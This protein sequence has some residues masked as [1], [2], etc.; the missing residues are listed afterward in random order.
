MRLSWPALGGS[1]ALVTAALAACDAGAAVPRSPQRVA[2]AAGALREALALTGIDEVHALGFT[3]AGITVAVL[4]SGADGSHPDLA[5]RVAGEACFCGYLNCCPDGSTE[6]IGAGSARDGHG[7]GT[8]VAAEIASQGAIGASGGAPDANLLAIKVLRDENLAL[9]SP[10]DL[11]A[12]LDWIAAAHPEVDVVNMSLG[13]DA[14][15]ADDCDVVY[16][17][18]ADAVAALRATGTLVVAASGNDGSST[19]MRAPACIGGALSVGAVWDADVGAQAQYC[20]EPATA[21]DR[22]ACYTNTSATTDLLAPGGVIEASWVDGGTRAQTG[23][24]HAAPLVSACI[25]A[26]KQAAPDASAD[27]IELALEQSGTPLLDARNGRTYPRLDCAAALRVLRP[28]LVPVAED[29]GHDDDAGE[30][31]GTTPDAGGP[32]RDAGEPRD[33]GDAVDGA[34]PPVRDASATD[35]AAA[36]SA[37]PDAATETDA[38]TGDAGRGADAADGTGDPDGCACTTA[39]RNVPIDPAVLLAL[40]ALLRRRGR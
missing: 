36:G 9:A 5:G 2:A 18:V 12:A 17:A 15:W 14:L 39:R 27:A 28:D 30:D 4:D 11:K 16:S 29:G 35:A 21:P 26:L 20:L 10:A 1:L 6:Q 22:I 25:A 32:P 24:S 37:P 3:G 7:H 40:F 19:E 8:H 31:A 38:A 23:T 13:T 34:L 33:A